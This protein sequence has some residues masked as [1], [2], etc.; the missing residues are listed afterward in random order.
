MKK[1]L[2]VVML[3]VMTSQICL[4]LETPEIPAGYVKLH[5]GVVV[6]IEDLQ[7]ASNKYLN[8]ESKPHKVYATP[9]T[10]YNP[11]KNNI[12]PKVTGFFGRG[13][14]FFGLNAGNFNFGVMK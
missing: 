1:C 13:F 6:P 10:N 7:P 12:E 4:A 11:H 2:L 5:S 9:A 14:N 3:M 8:V